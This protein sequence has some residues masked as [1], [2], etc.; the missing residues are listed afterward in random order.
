MIETLH[1]AFGQLGMAKPSSGLSHPQEAAILAG[2]REMLS[3]IPFGAELLEFASQNSVPVKVLSSRE[4]DYAVIDAQQIVLYALPQIPN[5]F[6]VMAMALG[7]GIRQVEHKFLGLPGSGN[8]PTTPEEA[9]IFLS[10]NID[11]VM[12][13]FKIASEYAS[14]EKY[15]KLID[16]VNNLGYADEYKAYTS[17][18]GFEEISQMMIKKAKEYKVLDKKEG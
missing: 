15:S 18:K 14:V 7:C 3:K 16:V 11:N 4:L 10:K 8:I 13:M 6:H 5:D 2:A 17:G 9:S 1:E 12:T